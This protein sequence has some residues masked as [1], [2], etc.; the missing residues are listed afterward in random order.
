MRPL[1]LVDLGLAAPFTARLDQP[2]PL[3][4]KEVVGNRGSP[5]V[6]TLEQPTRRHLG[7][8]WREPLPAV[9]KEGGLVQQPPR[10]GPR[11]L[12][13]REQPSG[14]RVDGVA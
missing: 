1:Q 3:A 6:A 14:G 13:A 4:W 10:P 11:G 5:E 9:G 12:V 2:G 7:P 8:W